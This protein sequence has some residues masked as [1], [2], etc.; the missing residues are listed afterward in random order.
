MTHRDGNALIHAF[1]DRIAT[2]IGLRFDQHRRH[3]LLRAVNALALSPAEFADLVSR[4]WTQADI[5]F[6]A[7][8]LCVGETYFFRESAAFELLEL[9]LLPALVDRRRATTRRLRLWSA[10]CATGEEAYSLAIMVSRLVPDHANWD[11]EILGTDIHPGFLERAASGV[12]G[13][14]SFRGVPQ[15]VRETCFD[16]LAD[17][18]VAVKPAQKAL[19]RFRYGNLTQPVARDGEVDLVLCRNVLMYFS[20]EQAIEAVQRMHAS[21]CDDGLLLVAATEAG[22]A[23]ELYDGFC[24]LRF[25]QGVFHRKQ[26]AGT[27]APRAPG[28]VQRRSFHDSVNGQGP[29]SASDRQ[30]ARELIACE[31]ALAGDKCDPC[32]HMRHAELLEAALQPERAREA[33][34]RALFLDPTLAAARDALER[35]TASVSPRAGGRAWRHARKQGMAA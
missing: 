10:G 22:S 19:T 27:S 14:W 13:E 21:L 24:E 34:R 28:R 33:L 23:H 8:H 31:A 26:P 3:D 17:G 18:R 16:L 30:L 11:I 25:E 35:L 29:A 6:L 32:L 4:P 15:S 2:D 7:P 5:E 1:G 9:Q 20:R 12:Y